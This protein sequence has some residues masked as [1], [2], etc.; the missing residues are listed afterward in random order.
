MRG[1]GRRVEGVEGG[2]LEGGGR[3]TQ[4]LQVSTLNIKTQNLHEC[5]NLASFPGST[6]QLFITL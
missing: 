3:R 1:G 5:S 6:P 2:G 4:S